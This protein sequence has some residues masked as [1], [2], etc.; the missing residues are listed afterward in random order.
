MERSLE[1]VVNVNPAMTRTEKLAQL[2]ES[3]LEV[4]SMKNSL[5]DLINEMIALNSA[6]KDGNTE[7]I[8]DANSRI[9][10]LFKGIK[11]GMPNDKKIAINQMQGEIDD[12]VAQ[13]KKAFLPSDVVRV[14][15]RKCAIGFSYSLPS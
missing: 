8:S 15:Q 14:S 5:K 3:G 2:R 4:D 6:I 12:M 9:A 11:A 7:A 1:R 10:A 13:I